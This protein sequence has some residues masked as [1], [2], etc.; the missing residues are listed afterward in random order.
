MQ[1]MDEFYDGI[2]S[3]Y[4]LNWAILSLVIYSF[5]CCLGAI[6]TLAPSRTPDSSW[7][8]HVGLMLIG[9]IGIL[10]STQILHAVVRRLVAE[11]RN[12]P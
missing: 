3:R 10:V 7:M 6:Q 5:M 11:S 9:A 12:T 8:Y 1:P 2:A 4:S